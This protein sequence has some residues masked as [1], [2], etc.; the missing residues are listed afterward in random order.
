MDYDFEIVPNKYHP[1]DEVNQL[2][3]RDD[4]PNDWIVVNNEV[5]DEIN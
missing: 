3:L 4:Y 1:I 2:I 5:I